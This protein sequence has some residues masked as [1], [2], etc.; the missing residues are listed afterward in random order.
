MR[1][2]S[3]FLGSMMR[4][5]H[6]SS[7]VSSKYLVIERTRTTNPTTRGLVTNVVKPVIS[8]IIVHMQRMMMIVKKTKMKEG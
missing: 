6:V 5:R 2:L 4:R 7:K 3:S 8:S 1:K